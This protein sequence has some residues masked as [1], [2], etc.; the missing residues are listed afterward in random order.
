MAPMPDDVVIRYVY[1]YSDVPAPPALREID[2][3]VEPLFGYPE[4][5]W[6]SDPYLWQ[7]LL[8]PEDA[9]D[10]IAATWR[11]TLDGTPYDVIY[12]MVTKDRRLVW[13]HDQAQVERDDV[14]GGEVWRGTWTVVAEPFP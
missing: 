12:R 13:I 10:A 1:W 9:E 5:A 11:T 7:R 14:E 6:R 8:H 4:D 2:A 3:G